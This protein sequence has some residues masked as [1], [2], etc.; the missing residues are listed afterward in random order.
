[1][2]YTIMKILLSLATLMVVV[3]FGNGSAFAENIDPNDDG[4]QYAYGENVGWLNAEPSG[5]G[6]PGVEVEDF[7][8]TG[9][10]WAENI[11]WVSL[12]CENTS[13]CSTVDYGVINDG[14]GN[15]SGYAW[16]E[17]VGWISFSC[18]NTGSCGTVEYDVRLD[19]S[20]AEFSGKAW[21]ENIGWIS[22]SSG[23]A[24]AYGV[25]SSWEPDNDGDDMADWWEELYFTDLNR[26]GTL[27][28]DDDGLI[29]SLEFYYDTDPTDQDSDGDGFKDGDEVRAGT[30]PNDPNSYP[31][32]AMPWIPLLLLGD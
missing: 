18:E 6:G 11:G 24:V 16:A 12:S 30:D 22:F 9:Y 10:I 31:S 32:M 27:D 20:T 26:D 19:F 28:W 5:D 4:S 3:A 14:R 25:R 29:D 2:R 21:G 13:S 7:K 17:N 8:L 23:G 15:L 1:M